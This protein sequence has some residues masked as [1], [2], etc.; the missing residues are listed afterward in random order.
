V[1]LTWHQS[2]GDREVDNDATE[3]EEAD[4]GPDQGPD[5]NPNEPGHQDA[6]ESE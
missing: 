3:A 2:D 4:S 6:D 1:V 5:A